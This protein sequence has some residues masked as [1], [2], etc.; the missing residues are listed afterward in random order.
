MCQALGIFMVKNLHGRLATPE[1]ENVVRLAP[2]W[3]RSLLYG[4][5]LANVRRT[6]GMIDVL[7]GDQDPEKKLI[8]SFLRR[9]PECCVEERMVKRPA[10]GVHLCASG[11][12]EALP[13]FGMT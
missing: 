12:S 6:W 4:A 11:S 7:F 13:K 10:S 5:S 9:T 3:L 2:G 8:W 1:H